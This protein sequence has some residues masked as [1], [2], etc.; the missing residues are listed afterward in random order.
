MLPRYLIR[1]YRKKTQTNGLISFT[2]SIRE[3]DL[4]I[5]ADSD[6]TNEAMA[7]LYTVRSRL[8]VYIKRRPEF[9]KSLIPI[10][11]DEMAP[12]P[13]PEMVQASRAAGVGP[14]AS[15]AG[16]V[17]EWV[18]RDLRNLSEN[19]IVENG[20]DI[21]IDTTNDIQTAIFA[22]SSPFGSRITI[23]IK[24]NEMPLG[25]CTSSATVGPSLSFGK[26]DACC[27]KAKSAALADA[28][29]SA[30]GNQVKSK[31]DISRALDYGMKIEGVLGIVIIMEDNLGAI[32]DIELVER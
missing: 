10:A 13:I 21:W 22:G 28:A 12:S 11:F 17:A 5:S 20:G 9:V 25:I 3:S 30:I 4:F 29:A 31:K 26:T 7:S 1:D 23:R 8:E 27:V 15:V 6:L 2:V 24:K 18:G 14:M 16:A 32:G 19:V